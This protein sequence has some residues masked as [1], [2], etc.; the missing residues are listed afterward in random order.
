MAHI[1]RGQGVWMTP[2]PLNSSLLHVE[3]SRYYSLKIAVADWLKDGVWQGRPFT[4][5]EYKFE[6]KSVGKNLWRRTHRVASHLQRNAQWLCNLRWRGSNKKK[7]TTEIYCGGQHIIRM[8][9]IK[10]YCKRLLWR[11]KAEISPLW[12]YP[13]GPQYLSTSCNNSVLASDSSSGSDRGITHFFTA[14]GRK[15]TKNKRTIRA[16][17]NS[18]CKK[19]SS[20]TL[21]SLCICRLSLTCSFRETSTSY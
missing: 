2:P 10:Q 21:H 12:Q 18:K 16:W 8:L 3:I 11:L 13:C 14:Q 19:R 7:R 5:Q 6:K 15:R 1:R 20:V 4:C 9:V 17:V